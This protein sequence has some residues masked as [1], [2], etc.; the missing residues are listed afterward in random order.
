MNI[1]PVDPVLDDDQLAG[2]HAVDMHGDHIGDEIA[3]MGRG[4]HDP[5]VSAILQM[6]H[7]LAPFGGRLQV[8][9]A[10]RIAMVPFEEKRSRLHQAQAESRARRT[11]C[12][13]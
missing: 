3:F 6:G 12:H 7:V 11:S 4:G 1:L 2:L 8:P 13:F 5:L 9:Y 10:I